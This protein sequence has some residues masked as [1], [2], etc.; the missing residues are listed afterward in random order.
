MS[1]KRLAVSITIVGISLILLVTW[2]LRGPRTPR[3]GLLVTFVGLT[4][5]NSGATLAQFDVANACGRRLRFGVGE[6]QIRQT[7]GWPNWTR[8]AGGAD[9]IPVPSGAHRVIA[10]RAPAGSNQVW[11]VPLPYAEDLSFLEDLRFRLDGL[12]W[13][14]PRWRPGRGFPVRHGDSYHRFLLV[15][16]PEMLG[17]SS[18]V[19]KTSAPDRLGKPD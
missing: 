13:S 1:T 5:N 17:A 18:R 4:N 15:Y 9:W 12:A 11:R 8:V 7:N 19:V 16:G 3:G 2:A 14:I 6:L 10:V